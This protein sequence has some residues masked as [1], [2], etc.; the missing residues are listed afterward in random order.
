MPDRHRGVWLDLRSPMRSL[1]QFSTQ[2][3]GSGCYV[4]NT[5]WRYERN[6]MDL[7]RQTSECARERYPRRQEQPPLHPSARPILPATNSVTNASGPGPGL[8]TGYSN[9]S[10]RDY[11]RRPLVARDHR[12]P[13]IA[14]PDLHSPVTA[15]RAGLR[16]QTKCPRRRRTAPVLSTVR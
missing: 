15:A 1:H 7:K 13:V 2:Q 16:Y 12:R 10:A 14:P 9:E 4:R 8:R 6:T 3:R 11:V 5:H